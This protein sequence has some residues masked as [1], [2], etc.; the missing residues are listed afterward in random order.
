MEK[1]YTVSDIQERYDCNPQTARK[2][3]CQMEHMEK[4]LSVLESAIIAW[5]TKRTI[6]PAAAI[7]EATKEM[8]RRRKRM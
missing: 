4:P 3:I 2:Y 5:E 7:R 8:F 1:L 6:A